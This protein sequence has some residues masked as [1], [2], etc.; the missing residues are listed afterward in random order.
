MEKIRV[1]Y[2]LGPGKNG[3]TLLERI[4][5]SLS[6]FF[7][8]GE[9][10]NLWKEGYEDDILCTCGEKFSSCKFWT[11][12][13][14]DAFPNIPYSKLGGLDRTANKVHKVFYSPFLIYPKLASNKYNERLRRYKEVLLKLYRAMSE[15]AKGNVLVDSSK[16]PMHC[17]ILSQIP[18]IELYIIDL[19]R[20]SR[21]VA[22]SWQRKSIRPD[23]YWEKRYMLTPDIITTSRRWLQSRLGAKL[24]KNRCKAYRLLK[25]EDFIKNPKA[26]IIETLTAFGFNIE[27]KYISFLNGKSVSFGKFHSISG[28]PMRFIKKEIEIKE[29][30][31]WRTQMSLGAKIITTLLT[32]PLLKRHKY[33]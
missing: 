30:K 5:G 12:V 24:I 13:S 7:P 6:M 20:D 31:E 28:N 19:L 15:N 11:K 8:I 3:S 25:Y 18:E 26:E 4:L 33:I 21:A 27:Q 22:F 1:I 23:I 9:I 14:K 2:I 29:D 16:N 10:P 32:Y 17:L